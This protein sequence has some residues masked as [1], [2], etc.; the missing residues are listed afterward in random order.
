MR[1]IG[2]TPRGDEEDLRAMYAYPVHHYRG[3][4]IDFWLRQHP[5]VDRFVILDD[6]SDMEMHTHRL[7]QTDA[8]EGLLDEHAELAVAM[9]TSDDVKIPMPTRGRCLH[10]DKI[11]AY[12]VSTIRLPDPV[13]E[14]T[15]LYFETLVY[16]IAEGA[17]DADGS[18]VQTATE[19]D[20]RAAHLRASARVR[21]KIV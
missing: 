15:G 6:G 16:S 4:E 5:E 7:V 18:G 11:G 13:A 21:E 17:W 8:Q 19:H 20:A 10:W 1:V 12:V 3:Y 2:E 14:I 9:L